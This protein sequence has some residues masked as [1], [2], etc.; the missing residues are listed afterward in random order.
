MGIDA[1]VGIDSKDSPDVS[2]GV[3]LKSKMLFIILVVE[4]IM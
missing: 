4:Y 1:V 3:V 2:S